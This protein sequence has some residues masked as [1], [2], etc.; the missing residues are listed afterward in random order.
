MPSIYNSYNPE[1]KT[2]FG[3]VKTGQTVTFT[4]RVPAGYG[5]QTPYLFIQKDGGDFVQLALQNASKQQDTDIFT[6]EYTPIEAG[7]FFYY[8]DL[9]VHYRKLYRGPKGEAAETTETGALYQL[10][11]YDANF[12]TPPKMHGGVMYQIFP[13]RFYEG[14]PGKPL[15]Y[16]E[17]I[18]RHDKTKEPYFWPTNQEGGY[19]TRDYFGGDLL[20]IEK[21][22]PYLKSLGVNWLY[23][24]PI[25]EAHSNHRYNTAD[26]LRVDPYLGTNQDFARLCQ[27]AKEMDIQIILDGVFSHTGSD[28]LY[29]NKE[30]RYPT[31]GAWQ[32]PE[33]PYRAW[34]N[35]HPDGGYDSWWGFD[36][37]PA[38]NKDNA[39]FRQFICGEGGVIDTWLT[40]GASGFRLDVADELPDS[41][42]AEIRTAVKKHGEDKLLIGE[43]WEDATT[44]EAYGVR[45]QYFWGQE[46]DGV[47]NYPFRT[48]ILNFLRNPEN[49]DAF[50]QSVMDICENYPAPALAAL[51][52]HLGTH[53]TAR[54]ITALAD[55]DPAGRGRDWQSGRRLSPALYQLGIN[56]MRLATVLQFTLPGVPCVY[57]GDEIGM[58]GYADPFN[59]AFYNWNSHEA[60]LIPLIIELADLRKSC[61]AFASGTL[62][63]TTVQTGLL[64]FTRTSQNGLSKAAVAV[65]CTSAPVTVQLLGE[66]VEI[67]IFGHAWRT[68]NSTV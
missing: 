67:P 61:P 2:P 28:S 38:C 33:S 59:R 56:R 32:S 31:L 19:L 47:M 30:A 41:F 5:C 65:N 13:D 8:F 37:L 53:D 14:D 29:F 4:L 51:T 66:Q 57:Y 55:Q 1:H 68:A 54:A 3:A 45:R 63:F 35:F 7:L 9:W 22:L 10:T 17:R 44:K 20:G 52:N 64:A 43:V 34:Y 49:A 42:I 24:N 58:Q 6:L 23:L 46:L 15:S 48:A 18:Y 11:V 40:L 16:N 39:D 12:T 27:K 60:R 50:V 25:F 21:K 36:T 26:Y 62:Q